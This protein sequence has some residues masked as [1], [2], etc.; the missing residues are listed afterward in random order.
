[1]IKAL[2][3]SL[4][5]YLKLKNNLFYHNIRRESKKLQTNIINEIEKLREN[6]DSDSADRADLLR[7]ELNSEKQELKHLSA[8]YSKASRK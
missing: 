4:N 5:L 8:F 7:Q 6:G 1:M 3:E 2:I